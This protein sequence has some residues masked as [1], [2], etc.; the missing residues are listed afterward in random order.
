MVPISSLS[1]KDEETLV[2]LRTDV[3][4]ETVRE[5]GTQAQRDTGSRESWSGF[6]YQL[7]QFFGGVLLG[8]T[9]D[10]PDSVLPSV[11]MKKSY[12]YF[13]FIYFVRK[14]AEMIYD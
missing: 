7:S 12:A 14:W 6:K 1:R 13:C 10:F 4:A 2:F 8:W 3:C 11:E 5:T 9:L